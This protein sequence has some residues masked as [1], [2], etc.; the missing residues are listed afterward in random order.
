M[1]EIYNNGLN[2]YKEMVTLGC[3][4]FNKTWMLKALNSL[5]L[6]EASYSKSYAKRLQIKELR[7]KRITDMPKL[8]HIVCACTFYNNVDRQLIL[9]E[10]DLNIQT[11]KKYLP[12]LQK[13]RWI[14]FHDYFYE[15]NPFLN[16]LLSL[17][18]G[19]EETFLSIINNSRYQIDLLHLFSSPLVE[20]LRDKILKVEF[21][22]SQ[23]NPDFEINYFG[24]LDAEPFNK[25]YPFWNGLLQIKAQSKVNTY[26]VVLPYN[27][28]WDGTKPHITLPIPFLFYGI[29]EAQYTNDELKIHFDGSIKTSIPLGS[30]TWHNRKISRQLKMKHWSDPIDRILDQ[31]WS[32]QY[33]ECS[34]FKTHEKLISLRLLRNEKINTQWI[35]DGDIVFTYK[36]DLLHK[37]R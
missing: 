6:T 9:N 19:H 15:A 35:Q 33:V 20:A 23:I 32:N 4:D 5:S 34:T 14:K 18:K 25:M 36:M 37:I 3:S 31:H 22:W 27:I 21:I 30:A 13:L 11:S 17:S 16:C 29:L 24:D 12:L 7:P 8:P 26:N 28:H 2:R 1:S 10:T